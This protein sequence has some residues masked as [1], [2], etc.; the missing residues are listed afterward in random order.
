[1]AAQLTSNGI[2]WLE[3]DDEVTIIRRTQSGETFTNSTIYSGAGNFDATGGQIFYD[4]LGAV[5]KAD[6]ILVLDPLSSGTLPAVLVDDIVTIAGTAGAYVVV[7]VDR[8]NFPPAHLEL[9]LKRG[10]IDYLGAKP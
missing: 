8:K 6:A 2:P 9:H 3:E 1:M 7:L 10:P 4:P 5:D